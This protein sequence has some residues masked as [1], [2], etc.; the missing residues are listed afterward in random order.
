MARVLQFAVAY[1]A[2]LLVPKYKQG[3]KVWCLLELG[4]IVILS[5]GLSLKRGGLLEADA[6]ELASMLEERPS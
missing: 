1:N 4:G 5:H 3:S 6:K 2:I